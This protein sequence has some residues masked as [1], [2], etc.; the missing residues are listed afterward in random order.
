MKLWFENS[1][2]VERII[3]EQVNTWQEVNQ[4]ITAFINQCNV[5][6][7]NAAKARYNENFDKSKVNL[8]KRYY[9]RAWKQADGRVRIDVGSHT[10]FFIWEGFL[11][12]CCDNTN[13]ADTNG[14]MV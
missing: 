9:T 11:N 12:D 2:G 1:H 8:F 7:I 10:E 6:K 13:T 14:N 5:N 3:N 4:A